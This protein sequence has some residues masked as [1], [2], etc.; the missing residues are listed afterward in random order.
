M[1]DKIS[2]LMWKYCK[3]LIGPRKW[4]K[5]KGNYDKLYRFVLFNV[6]GQRNLSSQRKFNRYYV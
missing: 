3:F 1:A 2:K 5:M 4:N 6:S